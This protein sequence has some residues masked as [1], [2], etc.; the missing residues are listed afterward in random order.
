MEDTNKLGA[1]TAPDNLFTEGYVDV[2]PF[3]IRYLEA[4]HGE[5]LICL[6]GAGGLRL[7]HAHVLLA[8]QHRVIL[9]EAPGFGQSLP[10]KHSKSMTELAETIFQATVNLGIDSFSLMGNSFGGSIALWLAVQQSQHVQ[11]LV[12]VAPAAIRPVLSPDEQARLQQLTPE[13]RMAMLYA[14]PEHQV[15]T[16]APEP[17]II[18]Q[19]QALVHRLIGPPRDDALE[20][21]MENLNIPVL[22]VFGTKDRVIPSE[23]GR[24]YCEKLP[25]C[26]LTMVYDAGHAVDADRPEAF[27]SVVGD[28]IQRHDAFLVSRQSGLLYPR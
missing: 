20:S 23:M 7:S 14:H 13:E 18:K 5:P 25:N 11:A 12:L 16:S 22:V 1:A 28:F 21:Q 9:F 4:G 27:V 2:E 26:H 10:N 17:T 6:H 24:H 19:Q 15:P 8:Q 3:C